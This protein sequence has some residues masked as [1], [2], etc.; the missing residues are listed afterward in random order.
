M[1]KVTCLLVL[2]AA[3]SLAACASPES[4]G[5]ELIG[6][7]PSVTAVIRADADGGRLDLLGVRVSAVE[8][9]AAATQLAAALFGSENVGEA[10]PTVADTSAVPHSLL[11]TSVPVAIPAPG[12]QLTIDEATVDQALG[13]LHPHSTAVWACSERR[14]VQVITQAPGAVS[15]DVVSGTCQVAGSSIVND[16][17]DWTAAVAI[18]PVTGPSLQPVLLWSAAFLLAAATLAAFLWSRRKRRRSEPEPSAVPPV[19]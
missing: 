19:H 1:R 18:G 2:I 6:P 14:T 7:Y 11:T 4:A 5:P 16:G 9:R 10:A 15:S 8:L 3:V 17:T 12:V 13:S